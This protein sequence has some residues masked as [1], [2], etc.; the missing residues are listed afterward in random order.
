MPILLFSVALIYHAG[1]PSLINTYHYLIDT[2]YTSRLGSS[3]SVL[4]DEWTIIYSPRKE[5]YSAY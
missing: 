1:T 4:Y 2:G 3:I 5:Y